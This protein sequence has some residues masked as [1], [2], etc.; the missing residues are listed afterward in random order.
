MI[1]HI[2]DFVMIHQF[3][4]FFLYDIK[5]IFTWLPKSQPSLK[6]L[7]VSTVHKQSP[8]ALVSQHG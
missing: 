6:E 8:F 3:I 4:Y 7:V 5:V 2:V 1:I